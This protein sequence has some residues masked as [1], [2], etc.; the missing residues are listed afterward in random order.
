M[1][2]ILEQTVL[3][4][5]F[6]ETHPEATTTSMTVN[7]LK[8]LHSDVDKTVKDIKKLEN[9]LYSKRKTRE[10]ELEKLNEMNIRFKKLIIAIYGQDAPEVNAIGLVAKSDRK[11][12]VKK[13]TEE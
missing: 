10:K 4:I 1:K 8:Q 7:E 13:P 11:K 6:L 2:D 9:E 3:L 5:N 12:R